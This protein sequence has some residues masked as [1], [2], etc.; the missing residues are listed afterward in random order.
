MS[1]EHGDPVIAEDELVDGCDDSASE[2]SDD[3][4]DE[5]DYDPHNPDDFEEEF[6]RELEDV[7]ASFAQVMLFA[8][9]TSFQTIFCQIMIWI[10]SR[11][12]RTRMLARE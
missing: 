1:N 2:G 4:D 6:E 3:D 10:H 5:L 12:L 11:S 7:G 8:C 9:L